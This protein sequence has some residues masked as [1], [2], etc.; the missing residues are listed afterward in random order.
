MTNDTQTNQLILNELDKV[1]TMPTVLKKRRLVF[2]RGSAPF[3]SFDT[4]EQF[5][6]IMEG[7][8]KISQINPD[9]AREQVLYLLTRGDMFD[10]VTLLDGGAHEYV[11]EVVERAEVVEVSI[12]QVRHLLENDS[13]FRRFFLPYVAQQLRNMENLA[14]DLSL[15]DVYGRIVRLFAR[16]VEN[17]DGTPRLRLINHLSHEEL[18]SMVGSVRKVVNRALQ[19]LKDEG[20]IELSRKQLQLKNLKKLLD[21]L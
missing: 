18:A 11:A 6:F 16:F 15:Y 2:E 13:E 7:S 8:I 1:V 14:V 5:Y 20:V 19:R 10:V 17:S 21:K 4:A 9:N 3:E 12:A